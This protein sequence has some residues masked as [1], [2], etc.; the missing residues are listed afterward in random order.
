[1][2]DT[3]PRSLAGRS[4]TLN[5][6]ASSPHSPLDRVRSPF[7]FRQARWYSEFRSRP[8]MDMSAPLRMVMSLSCVAT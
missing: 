6:W 2:L 5:G 4:V 8:K 7:L 1:M 3:A